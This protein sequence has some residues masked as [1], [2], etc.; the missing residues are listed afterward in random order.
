MAPLGVNGGNDKLSSVA[1]NV[2]LN[3]CLLLVSNIRLFVEASQG[4]S[5]KPF[6]AFRGSLSELSEEAFQ[7][8]PKKLFRASRGSLSE[9]LEETFQSF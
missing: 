3:F 6:T 1:M 7:S 4:F 9:L 5:R 2:G 8:F